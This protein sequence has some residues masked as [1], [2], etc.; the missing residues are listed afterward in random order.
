MTA[1]KNIKK[2]ALLGALFATTVGMTNIGH[3]ITFSSDVSISGS[4]VYDTVNSNGMGTTQGG[5]I[6]RVIGGTS[7]TTTIAGTTAMGTNPLLGN[8]SDI[9]DGFSSNFNMFGGV[10]GSSGELF[11]DFS[12]SLTNN[13]ATDQY[14]VSFELDFLNFADA[15]GVDAFADS[16]FSLR[17][18]GTEIFFTDLTSDALFGDHENSASERGTFG[19]TLNDSGIRVFDF[20][21]NPLASINLSAIAELQ[22]GVFDGASSFNGQLETF[23]TVAGVENLTSPPEPPAAVPVPGAVWLFGTALLGLFG[24]K[25]RR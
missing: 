7:T 24:F 5:S 16:Q 18:G 19:A 11:S 3:A 10:D 9:G 20:L 15:D 21:L 14:R 1:N 22:G 6:G 2:Y 17:N 25:R 13:S 8:L 4:V 12:F 23:L